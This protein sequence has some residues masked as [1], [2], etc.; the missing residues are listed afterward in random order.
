VEIDIEVDGLKSDEYIE[1]SVEVQPEVKA[2]EAKP[3]RKYV[4]KAKV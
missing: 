4:R 1:W 3:K 2:V